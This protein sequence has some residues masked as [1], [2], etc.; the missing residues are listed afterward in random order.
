MNILVIIAIG[1]PGFPFVIFCPFLQKIEFYK[2]V[3]THCMYI[4]WEQNL[5]C[6]QCTALNKYSPH[7]R[8]IALQG[9]FRGR[10]ILDL[11]KK[12]K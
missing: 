1:L 7:G 3:R 11:E 2:K 10:K 5:F 8:E 12:E 4:F 6:M 9:V